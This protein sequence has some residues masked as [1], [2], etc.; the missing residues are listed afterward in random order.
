MVLRRCWEPGEGQVLPILRGEEGEG[1]GGRGRREE[2]FATLNYHGYRLDFSSSCSP[3]LKPGTVT[4][5]QGSR[6][7]LWKPGSRMDPGSQAITTCLLWKPKHM[8]LTRVQR[9]GQ[10]VRQSHPGHLC[11]VGN[12]KDEEKARLSPHT[13]WSS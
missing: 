7:I 12:P 1:R 13:E 4:K 3:I 10:A 5:D 11:K 8:V 9:T 2:G 6:D